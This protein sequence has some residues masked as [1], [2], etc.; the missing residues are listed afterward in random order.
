MTAPL[1]NAGNQAQ[2]ARRPQAVPRARP[3]RLLAARAGRQHPAERCTL[4]GGITAMP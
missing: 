1:G 4:R 3:P 2:A